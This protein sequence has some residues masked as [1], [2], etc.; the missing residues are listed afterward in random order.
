VLE[1]M[2]L[3]QEELVQQRAQTSHEAVLSAFVLEE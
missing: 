2:W 3:T 1:K